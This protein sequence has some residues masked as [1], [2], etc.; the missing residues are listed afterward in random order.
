[1]KDGGDMA[2]IVYRI[3]RTAHRVARYKA[4]VGFLHRTFMFLWIAKLW[5]KYQIH[6][7][8]REQTLPRVV[9][10]GVYTYGDRN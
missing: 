2:R 5:V 1:M 4:S 7:L 9:D 3:S 8:K 10:D 6:E